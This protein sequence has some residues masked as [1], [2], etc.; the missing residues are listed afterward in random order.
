MGQRLEM[1]SVH[2]QRTPYVRE[3]PIGQST[4][5]DPPAISTESC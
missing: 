4:C 2:N 3:V 1:D 5:N